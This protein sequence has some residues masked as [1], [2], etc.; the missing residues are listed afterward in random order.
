MI[1][2][3]DLNCL[4]QCWQDLGVLCSQKKR[5]SVLLPVYDPRR[6]HEESELVIESTS[7]FEGGGFFAKGEIGVF[8]RIP[9]SLK[10][11]QPEADSQ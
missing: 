7:A 6:L 8:A 1:S 3:E 5:I 9:V 10:H 11:S 4:E 2:R